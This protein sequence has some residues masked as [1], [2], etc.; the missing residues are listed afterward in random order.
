M[1]ESMLRE[2]IFSVESAINYDPPHVI[3]NRRQVN[4]NKPF[5]HYEVA[6][7]SEV[8]KWLDY[9]KDMKNEKT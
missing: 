7:L 8:S 5:E 2:M 4:K 3:S 6:G 1:I 9:H